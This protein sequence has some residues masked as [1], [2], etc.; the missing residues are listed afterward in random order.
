M[1]LALYQCTLEESRFKDR[2]VGFQGYDGQRNRFTFRLDFAPTD[3][4]AGGRDHDAHINLEL[5][6]GDDR[7]QLA[8][9][10]PVWPRT[11]RG[12]DDPNYDPRPEFNRTREPVVGWGF[13]SGLV[14]DFESTAGDG[15]IEA[16]IRSLL[17]RFVNGRM[18]PEDFSDRFESRAAGGRRR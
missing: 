1:G 13:L 5:G 9:D 2:L 4:R 16:I 11:E 17:E 18:S 3:S 12:V 10:F 14:E 7:R 15:G 6:T 8:F